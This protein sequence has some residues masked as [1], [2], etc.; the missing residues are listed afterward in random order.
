MIRQLP[1]M[2]ALG[3]FVRLLV[4]LAL[5][6]QPWGAPL[7][8][9][10]NYVSLARA[11]VDTGRYVDR[12]GKVTAEREPGYP[13]ALAAAFKAAGPGYPAALGLNILLGL[14]S[15]GLV[16]A[17]ARLLFD[18]RV[19]LIAGWIA[20]FYPPFL[21]YTAQPNRE[22]LLIF[23]SLAAVWALLKER[24]GLAAAVHAAACATNAVFFPYALVCVPLALA[25]L[26]GRFATLIYLAVFVPLA[27]MWPIRNHQ[28]FGRWILGASGGGMG[29][30]YVYQIVPQEAGGTP[31]QE[32]ILQNDPVSKQAE[33]MSI[34]ERESFLLKAGVE[35]IK[36]NPERYARLFAWRSRDLW[37]VVPRPRPYDKPYNQIRLVSLFSDGWIIPLG[38]LGILMTLLRPRTTL[39]PLLMILSVHAVYAAI[40]TIIRYRLPLMPWLII[41]AA[42]ILQKVQA[43]WQRLV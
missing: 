13:V 10:D 29:N 22:C 16:A 4:G 27:A 18:Q 14:F 38:F 36:K 32:R 21:F 35:L 5:P 31:E 11:L 20:T 6:P 34:L 43:K 17:C 2:L 37:R 23:L 19:A 26:R 7:A 39:F 41:F 8:N 3:L 15:I 28:L 1:Q 12:Q 25:W 24:H 9:P 30:L 33:G 42:V 40:F